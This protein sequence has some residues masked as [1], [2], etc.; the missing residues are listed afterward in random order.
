MVTP[1][2]RARCPKSAWRCAALADGGAGQA[3]MVVAVG[4]G[5]QVLAAS[6]CM[7]GSDFGPEAGFR[8]AGVALEHLDTQVPVQDGAGDDAARLAG[9]ES[10][11]GAAELPGLQAEWLPAA[12]CT[13]HGMD[14]R[15]PRASRDDTF[16]R[17]APLPRQVTGVPIRSRG[18]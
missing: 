12:G 7:L 18:C 3:L 16:L 2:K 9:Y 17:L 4:H 11:Q 10:G 6:E 14:I 5:Q 8:G 1:R 13:P 15:Q